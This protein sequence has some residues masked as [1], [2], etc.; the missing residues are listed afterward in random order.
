MDRLAAG[1]QKLQE[2]DLLQLVRIVQENKTPDMYVKNDL[3]G[4]LSSE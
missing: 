1:L 3:E 4:N 2:D